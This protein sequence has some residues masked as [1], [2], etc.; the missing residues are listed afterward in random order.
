MTT[1][2]SVKYRVGIIWGERFSSWHCGFVAVSANVVLRDDRCHSLVFHR[3]FPGEGVTQ[4]TKCHDQWIVLGR[5]VWCCIDW[6]FAGDVF[7]L[8]LA[9]DCG[10]LM[11]MGMTGSVWADDEEVWFGRNIGMKYLTALISRET[12]GVCSSCTLRHWDVRVV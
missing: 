1:W 8:C 3:L 11:I 2:S 9:G 5:E 10:W 4:L 6:H 7:W 12:F